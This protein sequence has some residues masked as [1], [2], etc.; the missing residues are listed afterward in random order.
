MCWRTSAQNTWDLTLFLSMLIHMGELF[1]RYTW[2]FDKQGLCLVQISSLDGIINVCHSSRWQRAMVLGFS[3]GSESRAVKCSVLTASLAA[4]YTASDPLFFP[5]SLPDTRLCFLEGGV[6]FLGEDEG[7][8]I[9]FPHSWQIYWKDSHWAQCEG[10]WKLA[11][12]LPKKVTAAVQQSY[13]WSCPSE[14]FT[15]THARARADVHTH[16]HT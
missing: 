10:S 9:L 1:T 7:T 2:C 13:L 4:P 12:D 14:S 16:S 15:S 11:S 6:G 5:S 3:V 8:I